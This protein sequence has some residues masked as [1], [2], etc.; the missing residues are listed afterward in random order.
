MI[1]KSLS[2]AA[3][4]ATFS[5]VGAQ[6]VIDGSLPEVTALGGNQYRITDDLLLSSGEYILEGT[7][8]VAPG[9]VLT[10]NP[11]VIVR[12]QPVDGSQAVP[13]SLCVSRGGQINA[14]GTRTNPVIF[15]TAADVN[16]GRWQLGDSFL[17]SDPRNDPLPPFSVEGNPGIEVPNSGLWGAVTLLGYAPTNC[18]NR[19]T[20][21]YGEE[22][23]EGFTIDASD[24]ERITYGGFLPNDSSGILSYVSIR[25]SGLSVVE[26]DEQQGLT[27]GG[28]GAG[29][30]LQN[31]D[32][33]CSADDGIE[34]FGGTANLR[35]VIISYVNDDGFDLDQG[36][37]GNAQNVFVLA[38]NLS[39]TL[40]GD[41][42]L[43]TTA[44][45]AEWDGQDGNAAGPLG[46][47]NSNRLTPTGQPFTAPTMY[48]FTFFADGVTAAEVVSIDST[49]GG[50]LF[51]SIFFELPVASV[52]IDNDDSSQN[53]F[54]AGFG[55]FGTTQRLEQGTFNI[56]CVT[57][58]G[59]SG[60]TQ[61]SDLSAG[62]LP[63][64]VTGV[65]TND[66]TIAKNSFNN[67]FATGNPFLFGNATGGVYNDQTAINGVNPVPL[68]NQGALVPVVGPFFNAA[69]YRGAFSNIATSTL[70]TTGWSALNV[71]GILVDNGVGGNVL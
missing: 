6:T 4:L 61:A 45:V 64:V 55:F 9:V 60:V 24:E 40:G 69:S 11:G 28:V 48:N 1:K 26:G 38:S 51:N 31:I 8:F 44:S 50:N 62:K 53:P 46:V 39:A 41:L 49:F 2:F 71:R 18:G 63:A 43:I 54:V 35:N 70:Y 13:G 33:Y 32:I 58:I 27:L 10:I 47:D 15:T 56:D 14:Q 5:A 34:I 30:L 52:A 57:F 7:T 17:D 65:I 36:W 42:D 66:D 12:G 25:H 21:N 16:R 37:T 67:V 29:T 23:V 19:R 22:F 3:A 68:G 59:A 20:G